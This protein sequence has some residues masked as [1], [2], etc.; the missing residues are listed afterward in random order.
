[1]L[2]GFDD[3][4]QRAAEVASRIGD[5]DGLQAAFV[6]LSEIVQ[7]AVNARTALKGLS[8]AIKGQREV[9]NAQAAAARDLRGEMDEELAAARSYRERL[10]AA[11][12][13]ASSNYSEMARQL[14]GAA[15]FVRCDPSRFAR[16]CA[17]RRQVT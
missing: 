10:A 13:D 8:D 11:L 4:M 1:M 5:D 3:S 15:E 7:E 6:A 16:L 17:S 2:S 12:E 14:V 9:L